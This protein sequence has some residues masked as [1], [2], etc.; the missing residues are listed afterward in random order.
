VYSSFAASGVAIS[1]ASS[2]SRLLTPLAL[3]GAAIPAKAAL[4]LGESVVRLPVCYCSF[5]VS[6]HHSKENTEEGWLDSY[7]LCCGVNR[8]QHQCADDPQNK[9]QSRLR[10]RTITILRNTI[11][12]EQALCPDLA[13]PFPV[14]YSGCSPSFISNGITRL[15][16]TS[17]HPLARP[18]RSTSKGEP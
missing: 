12:M 14:L 13:L 8:K 6:S 1:S 3:G 5:V 4:L 7:M 16:Q 11:T 18:L 17:H 10:S 2:S 9:D 15:R